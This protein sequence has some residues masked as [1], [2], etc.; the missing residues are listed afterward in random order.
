MTE[1]EAFFPLKK[2]MRVLACH[3]LV[4][5]VTAVLSAG[6]KHTVRTTQLLINK[7]T[8]G[9]G[10]RNMN[11]TLE[12]LSHKLQPLRLDGRRALRTEQ[13]GARW[14]GTGANR[15]PQPVPTRAP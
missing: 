2:K 8:R 13:R 3:Q 12:K 15:L 7:K 14:K 10:N 9:L 5:E 6:G 4:F 11:Y 1:P